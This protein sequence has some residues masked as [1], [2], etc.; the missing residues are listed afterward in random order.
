M[1]THKTTVRP[2]GFALHVELQ[3]TWVVIDKPHSC[4]RMHSPTVFAWGN[5]RMLTRAV[6][7]VRDVGTAAA[8]AAGRPLS[9][10][11]LAQDS[12]RLGGFF[13]IDGSRNSKLPKRA[14]FEVF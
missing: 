11:P 3:L 4:T 9:S 10:F 8:V 5:R 14:G 13:I 2:R 6:R 7:L 12:F 1:A